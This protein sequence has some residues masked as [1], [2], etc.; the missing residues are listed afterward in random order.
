MTMRGSARP[1]KAHPGQVEALVGLDPRAATRRWICH[2]RSAMLHAPNDY[3]RLKSASHG[4]GSSGRERPR[5]G[6][7]SSY[8]RGNT[9]LQTIFETCIPRSCTSQTSWTGCQAIPQTGSVSSCPMSGLP[10]IL[11]RDA[12]PHRRK[13]NPLGR[14]RGARR[15]LARRLVGGASWGAA[16][17]R[18]VV[19]ETSGRAQVLERGYPRTQTAR[20]RGPIL[21]SDELRVTNSCPGREPLSTRSLSH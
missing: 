14:W 2:F 1:L 4:V 6:S 20:G 3:F 8:G 5:S 16:P 21:V 11:P 19:P 10:R 9:M 7:L 17:S 15:A 13:R 12:R 18:F